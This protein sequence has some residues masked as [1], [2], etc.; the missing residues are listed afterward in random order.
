MVHKIT[1]TDTVGV[2]EQYHPRPARTMLPDWYKETPTHVPGHENGL[3][4]PGSN[5]THT[6]KKCM[7]VFDALTAGYICVT[8]VDIQVHTDEESN[9]PY[10]TWS[11][12]DSVIEWHPVHQAPSHPHQNG[13]PYPKFMNP[14]GIKTPPGYSLLVM[15]PVHY[16]QEFFTILEGIIDTDSYHTNINFPFVLNNPKFEGIIPAGTP[17][18]QLIPFKRDNWQMEFGGAEE[19]KDLLKNKVTLR[20]KFVN[21]YRNQFWHKKSF[22]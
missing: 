15:N 18:A 21:S 20:S 7:P 13:F 17:I 11:W 9:L 10:Y 6:I 22:K 12:G 16:K 3:I 5:T 2:P 14:W 1:F 8:T 4:T 19:R